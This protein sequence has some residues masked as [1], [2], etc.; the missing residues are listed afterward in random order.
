[1][2]T[3]ITIKNDE[4]ETNPNVVNVQV[5]DADE[6]GVGRMQES[7][8]IKP[9]ETVTLNLYNGHYIIVQEMKP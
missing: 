5:Y 9:T 6:E 1:M 8:D 7:Y 2:T 3:R 4:A